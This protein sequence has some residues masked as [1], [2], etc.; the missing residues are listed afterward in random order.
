[1][2]LYAGYLKS[3][4]H[5]CF[6]C[7]LMAFEKQEVLQIQLIFFFLL[8]IQLYFL[9]PQKKNQFGEFVGKRV[10]HLEHVR[11]QNAVLRV[12][13]LFLNSTHFENDSTYTCLHGGYYLYITKTFKSNFKKSSCLNLYDTKVKYFAFLIIDIFKTTPQFDF[14][15]V[16]L[17]FFNCKWINLSS[18]HSMVAVLLPI[19]LKTRETQK[20]IVMLSP[21]LWARCLHPIRKLQGFYLLIW[22]SWGPGT[23]VLGATYSGML[24]SPARP[25]VDQ[26]WSLQHCA[27]DL[28]VPGLRLSSLHVKQVSPFPRLQSTDLKKQNLSVGPQ[29]L[30]TGYQVRAEPGI[31]CL[32]LWP[33]KSKASWLGAG[34]QLSPANRLGG[35]KRDYSQGT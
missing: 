8:K 19:E 16:W 32:L 14:M 5:F 22:M 30:L 21:T 15:L 35:T 13:L 34:T 29:Q 31:L 25:G 11:R 10:G 26:S 23:L 27:Q 28:V 6:A 4:K 18:H 7:L 1:M 24:P 20:L 33:Q 3:Y 2:I 17:I 9:A 12:Q